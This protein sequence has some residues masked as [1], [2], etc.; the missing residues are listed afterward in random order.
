MIQ[1]PRGTRD[2]GPAEMARRRKVEQAMRDACTRAGFGEVVTPTFEHSEL[3][4]TQVRPGHHRR[5]VRLQGQGR[6]RDGP[7]ARDH[8]VRHQ[9]LRQRALDPAEA[10]Q[11]VLRRQLLQ[12]REPA[13]RQVQGVLPAGRRAHRDQERR[14]RT[15]RSSRSRSTAYARLG[16]EDYRRPRR[17][18]RDTQ[19]HREGRRSR[20][21]RSPPRS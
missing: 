10:A 21:R 14:R 6:P 11:A 2:F 8:R 12:V 9:V 5:D 19:V 16:L 7:Q 4:T 1:R 13:E 20:T 3:F 18:H 17:P 15:P